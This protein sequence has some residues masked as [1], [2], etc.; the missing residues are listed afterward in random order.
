MAD[1]DR[2]FDGIVLP[3]RDVLAGRIVGRD[4][5][6]VEGDQQRH[7]PD[8]RLG[9][10]GCV[11]LLVGPVSLGVPLANDRVISDDE[12]RLRALGCQR[13]GQVLQLLSGESLALGPRDPPFELSRTAGCGET[14]AENDDDKTSQ[15][16]GA[17]RIHVSVSSK[18]YD[19]NPGFPLSRE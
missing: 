12:H 16:M 7:P 6:V 4:E 3:L 14:H 19:N 8:Q 13:H 11:M 17:T 5:P 10:R 2:G 18:H 9:H 15:Q 1:C